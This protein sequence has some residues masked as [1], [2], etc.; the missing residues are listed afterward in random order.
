[1]CRAAP[2]LPQWQQRRSPPTSNKCAQITWLNIHFCTIA[3]LLEGGGRRNPCQHASPH[4]QC[5]AL[6][7]CHPPMYP[8]PRSKPLRNCCSASSSKPRSTS[9]AS[10]AR[11]VI[12][13][14][15]VVLVGSRTR[16]TAPTPGTAHDSEGSLA[17]FPN[18]LA[19]Q[20]SLCATGT[21]LLHPTLQGVQ[22]CA[23]QLLAQRRPAGCRCR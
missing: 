2:Q 8:I 22:S 23:S 21:D 20:H 16:A 4:Y 9:G 13:V 10:A 12:G 6:L 14:R 15:Q 17:L 11:V 19:P 7:T 3:A 5:N 18:V 1:M